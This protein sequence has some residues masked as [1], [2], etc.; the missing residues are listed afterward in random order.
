VIGRATKGVRLINLDQS[1]KLV[2]LAKVAEEEPEVENGEE[3][4][5]EQNK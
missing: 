1:D 3:K 4:E 2:S 5:G